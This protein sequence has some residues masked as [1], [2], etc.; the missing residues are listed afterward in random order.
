MP[1]FIVSYDD[2]DNDRDALAL[3]RLFKRAGS[4]ISLAYVRHTH[5]P[6]RAREALEEK[7]AEE[8]LM[9]GAESLGDPNTPRHVVVHA[10]TGEGLWELVERERAD[11]IVFG[12]DYRT[13]RG[14]V[15]P[16]N[17]A[18]RLLAG[19]PA[20]IAIAPAGL[21]D[22]AEI[23]IATIAVSSEDD[24]AAA[25]ETANSVAKRLGASVV[26]ADGEADLL[27][28]G[29]SPMSP[30]G[31]VTLS[32]SAGYEV[33]TATSPVIVVARGTPIDF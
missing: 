20:A 19:G 1:K 6:K 29:S 17:S 5:Q 26:D 4:D 13:A 33:E 25:L 22:R 7:E 10:S 14:Q 9:R 27:I 21:R 23:E 28:V 18:H 32:A 12:S 24:D 15:I 8:L 16:G 11:A 2:T 3:G 30:K 31:H